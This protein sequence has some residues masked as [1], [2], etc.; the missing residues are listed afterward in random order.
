ML[1]LRPPAI[2]LNKNIATSL[3]VYT[4]LAIS[5]DECKTLKGSKFFVSSLCK[6]ALCV[7]PHIESGGV[8]VELNTDAG[9]I[10]ITSDGQVSGFQACMK[11]GMQ[12]CVYGPLHTEP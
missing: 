10:H 8:F 9:I 12:P 4:Y 2:Y 3:A 1:V 7:C 5:V 11:Q 6:L